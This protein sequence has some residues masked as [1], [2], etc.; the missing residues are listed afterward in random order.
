MTSEIIYE[1]KI[2]IK[3][4]NK[5]ENNSG[6]LTQKYQLYVFEYFL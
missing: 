2:E 1:I 6:E 5:S 3:Y 4:K